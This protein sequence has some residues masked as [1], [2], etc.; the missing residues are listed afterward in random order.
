MNEYAVTIHME[1]AEEGGYTV[2]VPALPAIVTEGDTFEEAVAM[3]K[4]AIRLYLEHLDATGRPV[5]FERA[6]PA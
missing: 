4:D 3:A 2:T 6:R 5:P 1:P